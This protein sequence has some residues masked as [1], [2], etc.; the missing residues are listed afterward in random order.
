MEMTLPAG[1]AIS[2]SAAG[3]RE[4]CTPEEIRS[5]RRK[6]TRL[7]R[8]VEGRRG[9]D[10]HAAAGRAAGRV[11][12][13]RATVRKRT[14]LRLARTSGA[15]RFLA[16]Y[17]VAESDGMLIKLAGKVRSGSETGQLT[18]T[19]GNLPQLPIGEIE[20]S[21]FGGQRALLVT[22]PACGD[23]AVQSTLTPWSGTPAVAESSNLEIDSGPNGGACPSGGFD[24][25][26]TA[27]TANNQAGASSAFYVDALAPGRR[28]AL[29][30]LHGEDAAGAVG[31][32]EERPAVPGTAGVAGGMPA[33][34]GDRHDDGRRGPWG[35]PVLPARAR[36][37]GEQDPGPHR[38][39]DHS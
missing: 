31:D 37:A 4:A 3:G 17:L 24:P 15:V 23:Y 36:P 1:M 6:R 2:P 30:R 20:L 28:T 8:R 10:R 33:G 39:I 12:L 35:G 19:F 7:P 32:P 22:P 11:D 29:R 9:E 14:C 38:G 21:L 18:V 5:K 26:F 27:G 16:L 25:S 13:P 34:L